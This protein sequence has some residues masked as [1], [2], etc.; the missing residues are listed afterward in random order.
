MRL[1]T[2]RH[3][4]RPSMHMWLTGYPQGFAQLVD[5][6]LPQGSAGK[7]VGKGRLF[8]LVIHFPTR[9]FGRRS[10]LAQPRI[11]FRPL[12]TVAAMRAQRL[13]DRIGDEVETSFVGFDA[14]RKFLARHRARNHQYAHTIP[15]RT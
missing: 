5:S 1:S 8:R 10:V 3:G 4:A 14:G 6:L 11:E 2:A 9:L 12:M 7:E 13:R 15:T